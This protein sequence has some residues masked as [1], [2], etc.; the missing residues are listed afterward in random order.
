MSLGCPFSSSIDPL[1]KSYQCSFLF[2]SSH[3]FSQRQ[4]AFSLSLDAF[5]AL[6]STYYCFRDVSSA[7]PSTFRL[8]RASVVGYDLSACFDVLHSS[9][10]KTESFAEVQQIIQCLARFACPRIA[11]TLGCIEVDAQTLA[12]CSTKQTNE[13]VA[14]RHISSKKHVNPAVKR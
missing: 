11:L 5:G 4:T 9:P 3:P 13:A 6:A 1:H 10:K 2:L 8:S 14:S 12:F 7:C